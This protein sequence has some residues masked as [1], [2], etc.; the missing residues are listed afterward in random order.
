MPIEFQEAMEMREI[1]GFGARTWTKR[2]G[3]YS[4]SGWCGVNHCPRC[5]FD[6]DFGGEKAGCVLA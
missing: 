3:G 4:A 5:L 6:V 1:P 2:R